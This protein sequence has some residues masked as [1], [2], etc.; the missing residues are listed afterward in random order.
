MKKMASREQFLD[1]Y[2]ISRLV[3]DS[4]DSEDHRHSDNDIGLSGSEDEEDAVEEDLDDD[5]DS[6]YD[7]ADTGD[8]GQPEDTDDGHSETRESTNDETNV[9]QGKDFTWSRTPP[10][11]ARARKEN[12]IVRL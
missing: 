4:D 7:V 12:L 6:M 9:F 2:E 5:I 1:D 3:C 8:R 11:V 10:K